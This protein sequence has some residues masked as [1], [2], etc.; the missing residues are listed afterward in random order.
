MNIDKALSH[1]AIVDALMSHA[2]AMYAFA[3]ARLRDRDL[4]QET[5][6][7][8]L[9]A[10]LDVSAADPHRFRGDSA[11]RSWLIGILKH[12]ILDQFRA[13]KRELPGG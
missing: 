13:R 1:E 2:D 7:Q 8:A 3:L 4:A 5:V 12:K 9:L 6:Q 11:L 10:A